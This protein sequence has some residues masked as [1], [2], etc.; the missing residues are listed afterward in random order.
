MNW[1]STALLEPST[2]PTPPATVQLSEPR[3]AGSPAACF[4]DIGLALCFTVSADAACDRAS[5]DAAAIRMRFFI[6]LPSLMDW[7]KDVRTTGPPPTCSEMRAMCG[8]QRTA[9]NRKAVVVP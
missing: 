2:M 5:S 7:L 3:R 1:Q 4:C 9:E 8:N 6:V